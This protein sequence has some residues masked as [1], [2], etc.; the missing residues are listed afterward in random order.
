MEM[1]TI[2]ALAMAQNVTY[3][4]IWKLV[5]RYEN[6][7]KGHIV[8]KNKVRYLDDYAV[9]Y[10]IEKR[11]DH[12][13]ISILDDQSHI[14]EALK[15]ENENLK[16]QI[17]ELQN[18]IIKRDSVIVELQ[19]NGQELTEAKIRNEYLLEDKKRL[20]SEAMELRN[21]ITE[22]AVEA[23]NLQKELVTARAEAEQAKA[24]AGSFKKSFFGFY[25]KA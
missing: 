7:L 4:A 13:M 21:Q 18:E 5:V 23:V 8:T 14:I 3:Q 15:A 11:K 25:R 16:H 19:K 2:K 10:I 12:P 6:E 24:E 17:L 1:T 22:A 20:Q 9:N